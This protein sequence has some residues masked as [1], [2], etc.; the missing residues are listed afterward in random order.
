MVLEHANRVVVMSAGQILYD[1]Q[2][3]E[4]VQQPEL[5]SQARLTL[6]PLAR[7]SALLATQMPQL[8]PVITLADYLALES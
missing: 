2:P 4:L 6:P 3:A 5:L 7:L 1:G 8:R